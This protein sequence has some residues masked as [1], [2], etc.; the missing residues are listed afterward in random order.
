MQNNPPD[1]HL[2][3]QVIAQVFPST[4]SIFVERV[5]EGVSTYVYRVSHADENFYLRVLPEANAT[6]APEVHVHQLLQARGVKVPEVIH[7]EHENELLQQSIMVTTEIKGM[8]INCCAVERDIRRILV[9]AGRDLALINSLPVERFGW[10]RRDDHGMT[11]LEAEFPTFRAFIYEHLESDL[12]NL[13]DSVL[14]KSDLVAMRQAIARYDS[15]LDEKEARLAHGD[16]DTTHIYQVQGEYTGII[17]FGEI[18]G[19]HTFYDLGHFKMYDGETLP[20]LVF[21]YLVEGYKEVTALP[22]DYEQQTSLASLLIAVRTLARTLKKRPEDIHDHQGL[23][24]IWRDIRIL[25]A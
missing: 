16:F 20:F 24:S 17:D 18:R 15:W 11:R 19:T 8:P 23:K 9:E 12:A 13:E 7:F 1:L 6:F 3:K 4:S 21:P 5:E 14:A 2:I 10:I 22:P 25:L